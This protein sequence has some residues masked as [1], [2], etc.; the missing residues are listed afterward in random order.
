MGVF[1]AHTIGGCI[2]RVFFKDYRTV[3][4]EV[5]DSIVGLWQIAPANYHTTAENSH[6]DTCVYTKRHMQVFNTV[7]IICYPLFVPLF[8]SSFKYFSTILLNC[9]VTITHYSM[10]YIF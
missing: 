8:D 6:V 9:I 3:L 1:L 5:L 7:A 4:P 2:T 10:E